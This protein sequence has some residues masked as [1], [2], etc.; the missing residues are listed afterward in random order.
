V[1]P[2][3]SRAWRV[4]AGLLFAVL[5]VRLG[6]HLVEFATTSLQQDF[7][8]FWTA[9]NAISRGLSPYVNQID[10]EPPLWDGVAVFRHSRFLYPPLVARAFQPLAWLPYAAAKVVWMAIGLVALA[11]A[12]RLSL[13]LVDLRRSAIHVLLLA[14]LAVGAFPTI[15]LFE[16]GQID[17]VAL[18]LVIAV[19]LLV[20]G[21]REGWAGVPLALAIWVKLHCL[22][23]LPFLLLARRWRTLAGCACAVAA[24]ILLGLLLNGPRQFREYLTDELPRISR[25]GEGGTH[26]MRLPLEQFRPLL[27]GAAPGFTVIDGREYRPE[28]LSFLHNASLV[29]TPLGLSTWAG[30]KAIGLPLTPAQVSLVFLAA[31]LGLVVAWRRVHGPPAGAIG[32]GIYWSIALVLVLLCAPLT[33]AMGVV[34]LLPVGAIALREAPRR[35]GGLHTASVRLCAAGVLLAGLPDSAVAFLSGAKYYVAELL[36]LAGLLGL[37]RSRSYGASTDGAG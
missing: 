27:Q 5:A 3:H 9:G 25:H 23:L 21:G 26:A 18:A 11:V 22:F 35:Q 32:D 15:V 30:L 33:W 1:S 36:C 2:G 6:V 34:W 12:C 16:R 24:L 13:S 8:A 10:A 4:A 14:S 31:G 20:R 19:P 37:W 17:A 29:R 7:A 28:A